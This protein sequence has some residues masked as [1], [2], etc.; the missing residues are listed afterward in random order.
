MRTAVLG[1]GEAGSRYA[2]DLAAAGLHVSGYDPAPVTTPPGVDRAGSAAGAAAGCDLVIGLTGPRAARAAAAEA[3]HAMRAGGCYADFNSA[4][5]AE[6]M[7]VERAVAAA[8]IV[9][10]DVAVLAPVGRSGAA[11]PLLASGPGAAFL[12][13]AFRPL[14][15][16]VEVLA[17][18]VG[19][20]ADR[21]LLRSVF[22][23]GLAAAALE[24]AAAGRAAG[25]EHW[26]RE[27]MAAELGPGG[28]ALVDR[29]IEGSITHA[30]R[31]IP[32]VAASRDVLRDLG[33]PTDVCD[34]ALSWLRRLRDDGA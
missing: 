30:A 6:K 33:V 34:A 18:P 5:A 15:A 13:D 25:C 3:A 11:T 9:M 32:E 27:Q 17:E 24:A 21:K 28:P 26:V 29:L 10:A 1:L 23:K 12:A 20:A 31:R 16:P 14:A 19:A 4:S 7:A 8:G 22:M 2:A